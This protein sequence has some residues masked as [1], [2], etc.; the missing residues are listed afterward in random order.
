MG[1]EQFINRSVDVL[2]LPFYMFSLC[3]ICIC[4]DILKNKQSKQ[5]A[6]K[7]VCF[8][9]VCT[10]AELQ[11][12][13]WP[14]TSAVF[15]CSCRRKPSTETTF[16]EKYDTRVVEVVGGEILGCRLDWLAFLLPPFFLSFCLISICLSLSVYSAM[17]KYFPHPSLFFLLICHTELF[18]I[19]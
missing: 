15:T 3:S 18:Q 14:R 9:S 8:P 11:V 7:R 13:L 12:T 1:L 2:P 4:A 10:S 19:I 6:V 16:P 5:R 17:N